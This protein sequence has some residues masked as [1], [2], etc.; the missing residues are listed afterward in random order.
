LVYRAIALTLLLLLLC[1][2]TCAMDKETA[3][4]DPDAVKLV[5]HL[6]RKGF[7]YYTDMAQTIRQDG[8]KVEVL[9]A[10]LVVTK[11]NVRTKTIARI[12][13][14]K[15]LQIVLIVVP[16]GI[17]DAKLALFLGGE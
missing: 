1:T 15:G 3:L 13:T 14:E 2:T 7:P 16:R 12:M 5:K 10:L 11:G 4:Q 6:K 8:D 17:V 9:D